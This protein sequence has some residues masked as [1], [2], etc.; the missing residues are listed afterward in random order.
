MVWSPVLD[1]STLTRSLRRQAA[2]VRRGP[3]RRPG[4]GSVSELTPLP[5]DISYE[6]VAWYTPPAPA[7]GDVTVY[8]DSVHGNNSWDGLA[9]AFVSGTNGPKLDVTNGSNG[10]WEVLKNLT[11]AGHVHRMMLAKG[12]A[13]NNQRLQRL[14][15]SLGNAM[16]GTSWSQ[17]FVIGV[18]GSGARPLFTY[19]ADTEGLFGTDNADT[20]NYVVADGFE[21]RSSGTFTDK[22]YGVSFLGSMNHILIQDVKVGGFSVNLRV[23]ADWD[24]IA[25][26]P[27]TKRGT[28]IIVRGCCFVD[29]DAVGAGVNAEGMFVAGCDGVSYEFCLF[30]NNGWGSD[31]LNYTFFRHNV[32]TQDD[33]TSVSCRNCFITNGDGLQM[34]IGGVIQNNVFSRLTVSLKNGQAN[35]PPAAGVTTTTTDNVFLEGQD[36]PAWSGQ[37]SGQALFLGN[38]VGGTIARNYFV[39]GNCTDPIIIWIKSQAGTTHGCENVTFDSMIG[40]NWGGRHFMFEAAPSFYNANTI[41]N[42]VFQNPNNPLANPGHSPDF[43]CVEYG[44]GAV[45]HS[46]FALSNCS[47][48][49]YPGFPPNFDP[50]KAVEGSISLATWYTTMAAV[51]C[52][53][54]VHTYPDPNRSLATWVTSLGLGATH[55]DAVALLRAQRKDNW[56]PALTAPAVVKYVKAGL[57][58]L[59]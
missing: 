39:G 8:A 4:G 33:C 7:V 56:N 48:S 35:T 58:I 23:Q 43:H 46:D 45:D 19:T 16:C 14:R 27:H 38:L 22:H 21:V 42:C 3:L 50:A 47:L 53:T 55:A 29:A 37:R 51:A 41:S 5:G 40:H 2:P 32:Y 57:G 59:V 25:G 6:Q 28:E 17:P 34:K 31:P 11:W 44:G 13:W 18:Y 12:S 36:P 52:D 30:D 49:E 54:V 10:A 24:P 1:P 15:D 20:N 9:P 26:P